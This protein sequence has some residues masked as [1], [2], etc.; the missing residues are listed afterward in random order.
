MSAAVNE[1]E[2]DFVRF[3]ITYKI[4]T[5]HNRPPARDSLLPNTALPVIHPLQQMTRSLVSKDTKQRAKT[6]KQ[7]RRPAITGKLGQNGSA[8]EQDPRFELAR[9][10]RKTP[11][12]EHGKAGWA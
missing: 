7:F 6:M 11:D 3:T 4:V 9:R 8:S 5:G 1:S 2:I 12:I 10:A